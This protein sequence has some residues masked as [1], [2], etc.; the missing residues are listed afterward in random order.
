MLLSFLVIDVGRGQS[1]LSSLQ[2][3]LRHSGFGEAREPSADARSGT[4][5]REENRGDP[6]SE[7]VRGHNKVV[8]KRGPTMCCRIR[9][10]RTAYSRTHESVAVVVKKRAS[11]VKIPVWNL[12]SVPREC[13]KSFLAH[14]TRSRRHCAKSSRAT[15]R[16]LNRNASN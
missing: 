15:P 3:A 5:R 16:S 8:Q 12:D 13:D 10:R 9:P 14:H 11:K 2:R 4:S 6:T 1:D 7:R